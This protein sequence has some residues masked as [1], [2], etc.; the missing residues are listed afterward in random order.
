MAA[1]DLNAFVRTSQACFMLSNPLL[2]KRHARLA[3]IWAIK[4][5]RIATLKAA[6]SQGANPNTTDA[7]SFAPLIEATVENNHEAV[8]ILLQHPSIHINKPKDGLTAL[9][10]AAMSGSDQICRMLL[11]NGRIDADVQ[12]NMGRTPLVL[13]VM[14]GNQNAILSLLRLSNASL[15]DHCG[16]TVLHFAAE[17]TRLSEAAT[18]AIITWEPHGV[19]ARNNCGRT[20]LH[21][22]AHTDNTTIAELLLRQ[23]ADA[24][25]TDNHGWTALAIAAKNGNTTLISALLR[26][27]EIDPNIIASDGFA[28]ATPLVWA[29][30][31]GNEQAFYLLS[32]YFMAISKS[33]QND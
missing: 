6:L 9:H 5:H 14:H 8:A 11:S 16:N 23:G 24:N 3:M 7:D 10:Y 1:C 27:K 13:A 21:H 30:L 12:D 2:Y 32:K 20:A 18:E 29:M 22:A 28:E 33:H 19:W 15:R 25:A 4:H 26:C 31:Y 17:N